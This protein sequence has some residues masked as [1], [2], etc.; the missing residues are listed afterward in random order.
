MSQDEIAVMDGNKCIVQVRGVRPFLSDK[1]DIT[2]HKRYPQLSDYDPK[3]EFDMG[4]YL[5]NKRNGGL[6]IKPDDVVDTAID[7]GRV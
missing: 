2:K 4:R 1:Y 7:V 5:K 3:N 6:K